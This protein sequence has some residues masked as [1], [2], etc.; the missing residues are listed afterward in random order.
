MYLTA[1]QLADLIDCAPNSFACMR[2][3]LDRNGWPYAVGLTGF[4]KVS[5]A[6]HD[7]RLSS[8]APPAPAEQEPNFGA[9]R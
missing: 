8:A 4:P 9:F 6:Y 2:R 3:W 7:T 5:K 1:P